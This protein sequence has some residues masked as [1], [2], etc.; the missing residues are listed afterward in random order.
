MI[1]ITKGRMAVT[2]TWRPVRG[3]RSR[4]TSALAWRGRLGSGQCH[5]PCIRLATEEH[6]TIPI[7]TR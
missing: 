3:R 7:D 1:V 4:V 6:Y 2:G 5:I